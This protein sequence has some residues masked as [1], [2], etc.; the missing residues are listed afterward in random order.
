MRTWPPFVALFPHFVGHGEVQVL[1]PVPIQHG[2]D[3]SEISCR[4]LGTRNCIPNVS[5]CGRPSKLGQDHSLVWKPT[6]QPLDVS[7]RVGRGLVNGLTAPVGID[8]YAENI[9]FV[10]KFGMFQPTVQ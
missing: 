6:L 5:A 8:L 4:V 1:N 9:D 7:E 2:D 3:F 10:S